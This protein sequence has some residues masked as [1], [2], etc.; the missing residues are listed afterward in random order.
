MSERSIFLNALDREDPAARAAYLDAACT[1]R[2]EL[3]RRIERLL[4]AH[5]LEVP[6]LEV[7]APEQLAR[8]EQALTFLAPPREP[9]ALGRL[10]HYD[11]LEVVGRGSTGMVLKARDA[12]LQ[13]VVA[14]KVLAPRL[15]ASAPARQR[16]VR[17]AQATAAVR[18]DH[19]IAIHAVSDDGP[20][21]YLV[22]EY[23]AGV[24]LADRI[25][26]GPL[27]LPEILRI[28]LQ[29]ASGLAAAH[30]QG[31][32]HRDVKPANILLENGVERVKLTDFGL[33]WAADDARLTHGQVIAGTP[34]F[35]SPEQARGEPTDHRTDLF[36]LGSVLYLLGTGSAPFHGDTTAAVLKGVG[37]ATPR[38]VRTLNPDVPDWLGDLIGKLHARKPD[39]RITSAREVADLLSGQLAR[40]RQRRPAPP[41]A[42]PGASGRAEGGA[43][44]PAAM[45]LSRR[46]RLAL[47]AGVVVLVALAALAAYLKPWQRRPADDG[48]GAATHHGSTGPAGP[49]DLRREDIPPRLLA[50]AGG[51]D[52]ERAP[53]EL[54]AVLGD[55]R[56]LLPRVGNT[57]WMD[58]SPDGRVLAVPLDADVVLFEAPT[59]A[60]LRSLKGPGG[61][62]V[63]VTFS[64]DSRL[65]AATTW[66]EGTGGAVRV[67]DLDARR[68]LFTN[69]QPGPKISGAAAFSPDGQRLVTEGDE[70]LQV[71]DARSG[72]EVQA[73]ELRPGG[74]G[75]LGFRPDGRHL[76][77]G[78][79][80]GKGVKVFDWGG[81]RLGAVRTLEDRLPVGAVAYSPDGKLLASGDESGF[82]LR[83]A[84]TLEEIRT[85]ATPAQQLAFA[86]DS[87]I[88]LAAWTTGQGKAVHTLTRWDV[89]SGEELPPLGVEVSADRDFAHHYLGRDGKVLFV[90][91][92]ANA[93]CVRAIDAA[94]GK[95]LFPRPG[96]TAPLNAVAISPDGRT[97]ASAGED[98]VVKLW[99]LA[100]GRVLHTL[101]AHTDAVFGLAFSPD[102]K[103]LASG[104]RDGTIALWDVDSGAE[105]RCLR[106]H[107]RSFSRLGFSPDGRALA[108][109][110]E[111]GLVKRWDVDSGQEDSPLPGHAGAVRCVAFSPDG[112]RLASGG[113]D[114][115]VRLHDLARGTRQTFPA[116]GA[117]ND[118]AFSPDGRTLAAVGDAPEGAV[119]LW[120]LATGRETTWQGHTGPVRGLAFSPAAPLLATCGDD[121][122][123]RLWELTGSAA[124]AR[125]VGPGPFGG[126]VRS[127]AFTPDGRYLT[128]AN[129]NG[130][131]YVLRVGAPR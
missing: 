64:R 43:G 85:V 51:G 42:V 96:H 71:W 14:L 103:Q 49:L 78:L 24:T 111:G 69:P 73:I 104:S 45:P 124:A 19:V 127:V 76:A 68:E 38:P 50:L 55:G 105:R 23:I 7:P 80:N 57:A 98:R 35:M 67:W 123:V 40:L 70:R 4:R 39:D 15:A 6:F 54:V 92:G 113:E 117:V 107:A 37:A 120:D 65:L 33:A 86:P 31:V 82:K 131:V 32:I 128:T 84:E 60:Y 17:E 56:F 89:V 48:P 102:G 41:S 116:P 79:W 83:N 97:L 25:K 8:G 1:G 112:K 36:S 126:P 5:Q 115:T 122:T 81:D 28:G 95:D 101:A 13:R 90:T 12:K 88:L 99:D 21:P 29:V 44:G 91:P 11:V 75:S 53:P 63:W 34:Q 16:F 118:L 125:T 27:A 26:G 58:Q 77:V 20:L 66:R 114:R 18:D 130:T 119:R 52:P 109:G 74:V 3:R 106:G 72:Q 30:G 47:V 94:T 110:G 10:D 62:V 46:R 9:G 129:A 61:R 2:T 22:M 87:R 121:G 100:A 108:A 59:G 93:T